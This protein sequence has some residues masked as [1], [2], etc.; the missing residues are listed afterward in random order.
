MYIN[1]CT[2][3]NVIVLVAPIG[4]RQCVWTNDAIFITISDL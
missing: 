3:T 2:A 1:L 4:N